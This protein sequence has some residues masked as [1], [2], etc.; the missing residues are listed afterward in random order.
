MKVLRSYPT[1][2][3]S[4]IPILA[5]VIFVFLLVTLA[6][7]FRQVSLSSAYNS[8]QSTQF[9]G[10][11]SSGTNIKLGFSHTAYDWQSSS[12]VKSLAD[13]YG[14]HWAD[15]TYLIAGNSYYYK[16]QYSEL[17]NNNINILGNMF[18]SK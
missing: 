17:L 6:P 3:S 2:R 11:V 13:Q 7:A 14:L 12:F 8:L 16:S 9:S 1:V 15:D 18:S 10:Q 5:L 4:R